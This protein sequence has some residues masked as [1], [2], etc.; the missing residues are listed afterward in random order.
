MDDRDRAFCFEPWTNIYS[1]K[2]SR[3][4]CE[5]AAPM[6][7]SGTT[8]LKFSSQEKSNEVYS[9]IAQTKESIEFKVN[10]AVNKLTKELS[11]V[12]IKL[13]GENSSIN[14][15]AKN[16]TFT[17][18][19]IAKQLSVQP[20]GINS[21]IWLE[22]Y[23]PSE[24]NISAAI[25]NTLDKNK[26]NNLKEGTP[27]LI[28]YANGDYYVTNLT[29]LDFT[30]AS[31]IYWGIYGKAI[32]SNLTIYKGNSNN[33]IN[34]FSDDS[35]IITKF[36]KNG[37][38]NYGTIEIYKNEYK[39][40]EL[41][42]STRFITYKLTNINC[43]TY[44]AKYN[45]NGL[46]PSVTAGGSSINLNEPTPDIELKMLDDKEPTA[47][48]DTGS[49]PSINIFTSNGLVFVEDGPTDDFYD[50]TSTD[51]FILVPIKNIYTFRVYPKIDNGKLYDFE[52]P[53]YCFA[54][55]SG[56]TFKII[57]FN[58]TGY[59]NYIS[60]Y[61]KIN[62]ALV[63]CHGITQ[64]VKKM[65]GEAIEKYKSA[66]NYGTS[67][68]VTINNKPAINGSGVAN[69]YNAENGRKFLFMDPDSGTSEY[70]KAKS[71]FGFIKMLI[72]NDPNYSISNNPDN[73]NYY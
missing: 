40:G 72:N 34:S 56:D 54:Q 7:N 20:E 62:A 1:D 29:K 31:V 8:P 64:E 19:V 10:N 43:D 35:Q 67:M 70:K 60:D 46:I 28:A 18:N 27:I 66:L 69:Y 33:T 52:L 49:K 38:T 65:F 39:Y 32:T 36:N 73:N 50:R 14:F 48:T 42:S 37:D 15:N 59:K 30:P 44:Y 41:L 45:N 16:S 21:K 5:F 58:E 63:S 61:E 6:L 71:A 17:G 12:G 53:M 13:D 57:G 3:I 51:N 4:F 22:I 2:Y 11:N 23:N 9:E 68:Y 26:N 24:S 47:M 55:K 25:K